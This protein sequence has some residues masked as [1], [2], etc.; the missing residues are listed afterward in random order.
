MSNEKKEEKKSGFLNSLK[1]AFVVT[2]EGSAETQT[3]E[4]NTSFDQSQAINMG[5]NTVPQMN[6][7][8]DAKF[9]EYL[10]GVIE[11]S[12]LDGVDYYEFNKSKK[13]LDNAPGFT[14]QMKYQSAFGVLQASTNLT[15][16]RLLETAD[17]YL[18]I[19]DNE[20]KDFEA[21]KKSKIASDVT[22]RMNN[23]AEKEKMITSKSEEITRL[24]ADIAQLR[25]EMS[26]LQN[27]AQNEQ[28]KIESTA[29][30]FKYTLE[31]VKA[32][33]V[34]DKTNIQTFIQ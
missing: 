18:N 2:E 1:S 26:T 8:F 33:I 15:K 5:N 22:S 20:E 32:Q 24:Q 4:V 31:T 11:K 13:N 16:E 14:E 12:N 30:N 17:H 9:H 19:L 23:V 34:S 21:S 7:A 3:K 25:N 28:F 27:E 29:K 6:G 10:L